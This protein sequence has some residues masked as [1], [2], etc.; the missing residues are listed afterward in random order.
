MR[1]MGPPRLFPQE[2]GIL[3]TGGGLLALRAAQ[4]LARSPRGGKM[5]HC[6]IFCSA[7]RIPP[8]QKQ[9]R[10]PMRCMGPPRLFPQEGG[11][12]RTGGG[13]LALRAAQSLAR[14]PRGGKMPH[15]GIFCSALRIPPVQK[16]S[17]GPM[18]CMG[19]HGPRKRLAATASRC[20]RACKRA[21]EPSGTF[22]GKEEQRRERAPAFGNEMKKA[23]ASDTELAPTRRRGWDSP[24]GRR[25]ACAPRGAVSCPFSPGRENAALRHFLFRPSNPTCPKAKQRAHALHGPSA[26]AER[27]GF[28][29]TW[30]C[31]QSA[32][33]APPL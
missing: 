31:S 2:G 4:S 17:R 23:G 25:P 32:F 10:G 28:E 22:C 16:Q 5:P 18:R 1:C 29:P 19:P 7:L 8:V 3:R 13:L 12:L 11:I 9:S 30:D 20:E 24:H 6:G 21:G 15:C 33:E 14:S 27:V 26:L